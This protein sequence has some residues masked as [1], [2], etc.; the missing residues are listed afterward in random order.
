MKKIILKI[1]T[2]KEIPFKMTRE[3]ETS[4]PTHFC[5]EVIFEEKEIIVQYDPV[6]ELGFNEKEFIDLVKLRYKKTLDAYSVDV[7]GR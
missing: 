1:V 5:K 2:R 4:F 7:V 3:Q 6:R